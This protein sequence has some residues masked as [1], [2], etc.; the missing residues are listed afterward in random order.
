MT[1]IYT[2]SL[3]ALQA[4]LVARESGVASRKELKLLMAVADDERRAKAARSAVDPAPRGTAAVVDLE[5]ARLE[6]EWAR[7]A[8]P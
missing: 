6:R 2:R 1:A 8:A 5:R 7:A 3:P 4:F